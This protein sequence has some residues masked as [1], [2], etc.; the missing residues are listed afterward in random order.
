M[1]LIRVLG[2]TEEYEMTMEIDVGGTVTHV[3]ANSGKI[4]YGSATKNGEVYF[5]FDPSDYE[6]QKKRAENA[7]RLLEYTKHLYADPANNLPPSEVK[8]SQKG[9]TVTVKQ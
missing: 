1:R 8:A 9:A 3:V 7:I 2:C 5:T 6:S 4:T